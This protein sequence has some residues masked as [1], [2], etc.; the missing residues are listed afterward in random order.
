MSPEEKEPRERRLFRQVRGLPS[1]ERRAFLASACPDPVVRARLEDLLT[2]DAGLGAFLEEPIP[3]IEPLVGDAGAS[4]LGSTGSGDPIAGREP[5]QAGPQ[6]EPLRQLGPYQLL[7]LIGIGGM[8]R[9]Y[10]ARRVDGEVRQEVAIKVLQFAAADPAT[11][12]HFDTERQILAQLEHPNIA[13]LLSWGSDDQGMPYVVMELVHGEPITTYCDRARL[14]IRG[15][16]ELMLKVCGAVSYAHENLVVHRDLKPSNILVDARG[17]PKLLDFGIAKLLPLVEGE[18]GTA[19]HARILT[20]SYASP[21]HAAGGRITTASDTYSLG[22]LLYRLLVGRLPF[23]WSRHTPL[24]IADSLRRRALVPP[25]RAVLA[26]SEEEAGDEDRSEATVAERMRTS[27]QALHRALRGDLDAIVVK[28]LQPDPALRYPSAERLA[29]DI[30]RLL[31]GLPVSAR[32]PRWSYRAAKFVRRHAVALAAT[33]AAGAAILILAILAVIQSVRLADQ[34]DRA[35]RERLKATEVTRALLASFGAVDPFEEPSGAAH[36]TAPEIL[37]RASALSDGELAQQ[38]DVRAA[39]EHTLGSIYL[40]LGLYEKADHFLQA[41]LDT[42]RNLHGEWDPEVASSLLQ[43]ARL[44]LAQGEFEASA[45]LGARALAIH[46]G[47]TEPDELAVAEDRVL[48][49]EVRSASGDYQTAVSQLRDVL[50]VQR[51][52]LGDTDLAVSDTLGALSRTLSLAGDFAGAES[53][54]REAMGIDSRLLKPEHPHFGQAVNL[55]AGALFKQGKFDEAEALFRRRLAHERESLG[56][57]H[58]QVAELKNNLANLLL[59]RQKFD[60]AESLAR[61]ALEV[62]RH[63]LGERHPDVITVI[64]NLALIATTRG[65]YGTA[66]PLARQALQLTREVFGEDNPLTLLRIN[67]LSALLMKKGDYEAAVPLCLEVVARAERL[68]PGTTLGL[69]LG[70][71]VARLGFVLLQ[72]HRYGEANN[73]LAHSEEVFKRTL[74]ADDWRVANVR[75]LRAASLTG[76]RRFAEAE[77]LLFDSYPILRRSQGADA[78]PTRRA[79]EFISQLDAARGR[80]GSSHDF[81]E[82]L[83]GDEASSR[84]R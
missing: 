6:A 9:V 69:D 16:L 45:E 51:R 75:A 73:S 64:N 78:A 25:S 82:R 77:Q 3:W 67:N 2:E 21:E 84:Q 1:A 33:A 23:D 31:A 60:E 38:P 48:L 79:R 5:S 32:P 8:G 83:E 29:E 34:R 54:A 42:R 62:T 14:R 49:A 70:P 76:L 27:A 40:R 50:V 57:D 81:L 43:L 30:E 15:R 44:R 11:L 24:E 55:L 12:R 20:P 22:V 4:G 37:E 52:L 7:E 56:D 63:R 39:L 58:L 72:T 26:P 59:S 46:R 65:D 36:V 35:E 13:R 80:P 53:T 41:A 28:A 61:Q 19:T 18:A 71:A 17:E 47:G 66:E 74:P 68:P 10:R